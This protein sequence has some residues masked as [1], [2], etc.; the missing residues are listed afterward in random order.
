MLFKPHF[1]LQFSTKQQLF[2][3]DIGL[4]GMSSLETKPIHFDWGVVYEKRI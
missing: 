1:R 4:F 3:S 2:T